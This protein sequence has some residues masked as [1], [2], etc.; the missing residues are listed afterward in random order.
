MLY[1]NSFKSSFLKYFTNYLN[2]QNTPKVK[3]FKA[4]P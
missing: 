4:R 2:L 1:F 3:S